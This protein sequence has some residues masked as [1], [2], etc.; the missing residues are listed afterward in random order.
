MRESKAHFARRV[1]RDNKKASQ[2]GTGTSA[3]TLFGV[4][5]LGENVGPGEGGWDMYLVHHSGYVN[6]WS[7]ASVVATF[8]E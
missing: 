8:G 6:H 7:A 3:T 2:I 5:V 1:Q 4:A